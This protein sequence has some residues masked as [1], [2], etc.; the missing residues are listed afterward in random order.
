[1][2]FLLYLVNHPKNVRLKSTAVGFINRRE[3]GVW[4]NENMV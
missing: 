2:S 1:M 3:A 4:I